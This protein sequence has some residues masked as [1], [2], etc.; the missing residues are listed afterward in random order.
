M[1]RIQV[2]SET[3]WGKAQD[4]L[5]IAHGIKFIQT[6]GHGGFWISPSRLRTLRKRF[7]HLTGTWVGFPWFEEDE[8]WG[9]VVL[10]WPKLFS[11]NERKAAERAVGA[12]S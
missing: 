2:G 10:A 12:Q 11:A 4:V 3:P 6:G 7:P 5:I 1:K 9:W 8:D